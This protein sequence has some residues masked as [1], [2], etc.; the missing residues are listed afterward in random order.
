MHWYTNI[1]DGPDVV[2]EA[3]MKELLNDK[4]MFAKAEEETDLVDVIQKNRIIFIHSNRQHND[5]I[6]NPNHFQLLLEQSHFLKGN[7][8]I[9][10]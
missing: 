10:Y 7:K 3:F 1:G 5:I 8:W 4:L 6:N 9:E 2:S